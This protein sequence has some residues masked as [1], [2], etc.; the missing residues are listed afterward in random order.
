MRIENRVA[1]VG[2]VTRHRRRV[3]WSLIALSWILWLPLPVMAWGGGRPESP[4][5]ALSILLVSQAI[6][7]GG[8]VLARPHFGAFRQKAGTLLCVP[9][10]AESPDASAG[11]E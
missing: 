3:G 5:L 2:P 7:W 4:A 11:H 9:W 10:R 6:F 8:A 1:A